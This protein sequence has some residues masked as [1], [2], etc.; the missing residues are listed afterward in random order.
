MVVRIT[1]PKPVSSASSSMRALR[2][3]K[4][5]HRLGSLPLF[6]GSGW[7]LLHGLFL[8]SCMSRSLHIICCLAPQ[9]Q[10]SRRCAWHTPARD[11]LSVLATCR[12]EFTPCMSLFFKFKLQ[13]V[14]SGTRQSSFLQFEIS[15]NTHLKSRGGP[16]ARGAIQ[17][18]HERHSCA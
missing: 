10:C 14:D 11:F 16:C 7:A 5:E 6:C 12:L 15:N 13:F 17:N 9:L 18:A 4:S 8:L 3:V 1:L 2:A